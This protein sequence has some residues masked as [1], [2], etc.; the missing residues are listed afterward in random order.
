M[1]E[2]SIVIPSINERET[3]GIC[4]D[5]I[6]KVFSENGLESE[7][8]VA[9]NSDDDTPA[10]ANRMGA[11]VITP[12]K[13]G[14]GYAYRYAFKYLKNKHGRYPKYVI[15]GDADN[16]YDFSEIP[17]LLK[18]L[19]NG[20][21]DLVIGSRLKGKMEKKAM[22]WL[23]RYI[24]NPILTHFLNFF[25]KAG[26]S[27]AHSGFRAIRGEALDKLELHS[28]G[29]E[30]ASEM[31]IEATK[32]ELKIVEVPITYHRR[33][34]G[35]SKLSSLQDGWRHL[36][37]ML[38]HAPKYLYMYPGATL[39][40]AGVMLIL[41][42]LLRVNLGY[43]PGIH[44]SIAGSLLVSLGFQSILFGVFAKLISGEKLYRFLTLKRAST[45]GAL[46]S[47]IGLLW[48]TKI[49]LDWVWSGFK[50]FPP[51]VH[52][53]ICLTLIAL[54]IQLILSSLM[55]S[56]IAEHRQRWAS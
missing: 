13:R 20:E 41:S 31:L 56:I 45:I 43:S 48:T 4:I 46:I 6:R 11:E 2:V 5:K 3:I 10:I 7:I 34:H 14:Y 54:G 24:G 35:R 16:T 42:A 39:M 22:P 37:F 44:T 52:S 9:D 28:D 8:I 36:K 38:I 27:D 18:P 50:T 53:V 55:L 47:T 32:K 17:K 29:M 15:I 21:A 51:V 30:F 19:I 12:D 33:T 40:A 49:G 25:F 1:V 23:H 26:V